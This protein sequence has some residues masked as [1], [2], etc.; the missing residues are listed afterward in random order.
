[1]PE[2]GARIIALT[3]YCYNGGFLLTEI[4]AVFTLSLSRSFMV[5][6]KYG[7]VSD[8]EFEHFLNLP[9]KDQ[10]QRF[11]QNNQII[12]AWMKVKKYVLYRE[13]DK[14]S[15][16]LGVNIAEEVL[17]FDNYKQMMAILKGAACQN[18]VDNSSRKY[19]LREIDGGRGE[20]SIGLVAVAMYQQAQ[21]LVPKKK[22]I[23]FI[24]CIV[25]NSI[26]IASSF[27]YFRWERTGYPLADMT[28]MR[29]EE[30]LG[31]AKDFS[32][33][34]HFDL[35]NT[36]TLIWIGLFVAEMQ[37][38]V[39]MI[40]IVAYVHYKRKAWALK[41]VGSLIQTKYQQ[42]KFDP[43]IMNLYQPAI[44]FTVLNNAQSWIKLRSIVIDLGSLYEKRLNII[45][46][47]SVV[48]SAV[49]AIGTVISIFFFENAT[50]LVELSMDTTLTMKTS[51]NFIFC[52]SVF[53]FLMLMAGDEANQQSLVHRNALSQQ[54]L[55]VVE[56]ANLIVR[57]V[58]ASREVEACL[59]ECDAVADALETQDRLYPVTLFG[60]RATKMY[61]V[62]LGSLVFTTLLV[63]LRGIVSSS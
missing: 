26:Y 14:M 60:A 46:G 35:F 40:N 11:Q 22:M 8:R 37:S 41:E 25:L 10:V 32:N 16:S 36:I 39:Q 55:R 2:Q 18:N 42:D 21:D 6:V 54:R 12:T 3:R 23:F 34:Q 51:V 7:Y 45:V 53:C 17:V 49:V 30:Q 58:D 19:V 33:C 31:D 59:T 1:M 44:S 20:A 24:A 62:K 57:D 5:G 9:D 47:S 56:A 52:M 13:V 48:V 29:G 61:V 43:S 50:S 28:C 27:F 38:V 63:I 15:L 4:L